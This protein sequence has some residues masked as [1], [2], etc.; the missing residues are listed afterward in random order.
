MKHYFQLHLLVLLFATTAILGKMISLPAAPLVVW[1]TAIAAAGAAAWVALVR[2]HPLWPGKRAAVSLFAIGLIIGL[3]WVCFFAAIRLSNV[4][5]CL[6]GMATITLFTAF[7]EPLLEKR[8]V[9]PVEVLLGLLVIAGIVL[10]AGY[11]PGRLLGLAVAIASAFLA[12]I[13]PVLNRRLV[14]K[15][16]DPLMM[17]GWEML[18][19]CA[20][21]LAIVPFNGGW[22]PLLSWQGLDWLWLLLLALVCTVFSHGYHIHLLRHISAYASNLAINF[23]PVYGIIAAALLFGEH[24][25]L[26]PMFYVGLLTILAANALHPVILRRAKHRLVPLTPGDADR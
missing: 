5:I 3:H 2:R 26:H 11:E 21:A 17:V 12:A 6:A 4:S 22:A 9:R 18:G 20:V 1:R 25:R 8:R 23:E 19:A 16:G 24:Q 7:T 10:V 15:G 13:F 14:T